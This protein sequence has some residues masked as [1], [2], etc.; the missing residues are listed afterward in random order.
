MHMFVVVARTYQT[1]GLVRAT[2]ACSDGKV[3]SAAI[4]M[5]AAFVKARGAT[6]ETEE[7]GTVTYDLCFGGVFLIQPALPAMR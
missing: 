7:W 4:D 1:A 5:P 3:T 2:C 6:I